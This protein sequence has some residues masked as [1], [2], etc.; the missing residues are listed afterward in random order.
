MDFSDTWHEYFVD[1][2]GFSHLLAAVFAR[3]VE[4]FRDGLSEICGMYQNLKGRHYGWSWVPDPFPVRIQP[5]PWG[6]GPL[7][8]GTEWIGLDIAPGTGPGSVVRFVDGSARAPALMEGRRARVFCGMGPLI[9]SWFKRPAGLSGV[10]EGQCVVET[11][12]L[13]AV[14]LALEEIV[15]PDSVAHGYN[16]AFEWAEHA[17]GLVEFFQGRT[18]EWIWRAVPRQFNPCYFGGPHPIN[19]APGSRVV[20]PPPDSQAEEAGRVVDFLVP[21]RR[22]RL[23]GALPQAAAQSYARLLGV[24]AEAYDLPPCTEGVRGDRCLIRGAEF[25]EMVRAVFLRPVD[26]L[27]PFVGCLAGMYEAIERRRFG[28][29]WIPERLPCRLIPSIPAYLGQRPTLARGDTWIGRAPSF[30]APSDPCVRFTAED[31]RSLATMGWNRAVLFAGLAQIASG[32]RRMP[33]GIPQVTG[34]VCPLRDAEFL[35]FLPGDLD[36]PLSELFAPWLSHAAGLAEK[37]MGHSRHWFSSSS[38]VPPVRYARNHPFNPAE[39]SA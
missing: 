23:L 10:T 8:S 11:D 22:E 20:E 17:T 29:R 24:I 3:P 18:R 19:P 30:S 32:E 6:C 36:D 39:N 26:L 12:A 14:V 25:A 27:T 7:R 34:P 28:W 15:G 9:A 16:W 5:A 37:L 1:E 31:G 35:G 2:A 33:C 21:G 38:T 4:L 13:D